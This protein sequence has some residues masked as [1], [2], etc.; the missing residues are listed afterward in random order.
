MHDLKHLT[1][2]FNGGEGS[3]LG[4]DFLYSAAYRSRDGDAFFR[5]RR[6]G[7]GNFSAPH[8]SQRGT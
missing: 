1:F 6:G 3:H 7:V 5:R 2:D 4:Q 8:A